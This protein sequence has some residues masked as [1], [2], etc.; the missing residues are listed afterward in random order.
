MIRFQDNFYLTCSRNLVAFVIYMDLSIL[1]PVW[2]GGGGGGLRVFAKYPK[3][4]FAD[5]HQTL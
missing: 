2:T 1:N 5:L 4:G 3:N